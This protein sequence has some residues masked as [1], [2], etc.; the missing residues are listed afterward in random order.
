LINAAG[1]HLSLGTELDFGFLPLIM[2]GAVFAYFTL[3]ESF[4]GATAGKMIFKVK[5]LKEDGSPCSFSAAA[6]RNL[7]RFIDALPFL[8]LIGVILM[9]RSEKKQRLGDRVAKTIV[10]KPRGEYPSLP[11]PPPTY[12]PLPAPT[13]TPSSYPPA[14]REPPL[15]AK[16]CMN[17]GTPIPVRAMFCPRCGTRQ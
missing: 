3:M 16:Y 5:V 17:C 7:L 4:L 14:P 10:V 6:V 12:P 13:Y 2:I 15:S 11:P 1:I 8:Y 9:F